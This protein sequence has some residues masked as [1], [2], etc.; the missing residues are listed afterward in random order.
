VRN[1]RRIHSASRHT[2]HESTEP[3]Y[4][5]PLTVT[6]ASVHLSADLLTAGEVVAQEASVETP[7]FAKAS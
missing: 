4:L 6:A 5:A 2:H 7:L 1:Q 3:E